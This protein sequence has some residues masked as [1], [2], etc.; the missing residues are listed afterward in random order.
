MNTLINRRAK[1]VYNAARLLNIAAKDPIIPDTWEN[2]EQGFKDYFIEVITE[3]IN[4][5]LSFEE[6]HNIWMQKHFAMGWVYGEKEDTI[7]LTHP[8]LIPYN[9]LGQLDQDKD[10]VIVSLCKIAVQWIRK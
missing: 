4:K 10:A 9:Q 2:R 8:H 3:T 6:F 1:F 5:S 7:K